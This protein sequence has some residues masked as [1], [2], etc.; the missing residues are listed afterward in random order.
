MSFG[1]FLKEKRMKKNLTLRQMAY[2][3]G[4]SHT[5]ISDIEKEVAAKPETIGIIA[6]VLE[7]TEEEKRYVLKEIMY[8]KTPDSVMEE[9]EGLKRAKGNAQII[10]EGDDEFIQIPVYGDISAGNGRIMYGDIV[11]Y[12]I[13]DKN[14][15]NIDELIAVRVVGDSMESKIPDG[16]QVLIRR[17]V[18]VENGNVGAFCIGEDCYVKQLKI[19]GGTPVLKSFNTSYSEI[20]VTDKD[21]FLVVGKI[22]EC[23]IKF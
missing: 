17:G 13:L 6:D 16:S 15:K 19:Y 20:E 21:E 7:L 4:F 18:E 11:D 2:K 22:I 14:T 8:F 12:Y 23:K 5:Y 1:K 10:S 3:T 9:L